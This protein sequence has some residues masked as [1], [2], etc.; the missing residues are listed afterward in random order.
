MIWSSSVMLRTV[1]VKTPAWVDA[2]N[3]DAPIG[4]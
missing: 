3:C 4:W 2:K 1:E